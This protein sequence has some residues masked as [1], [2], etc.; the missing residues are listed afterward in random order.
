MTDQTPTAYTIVP[1]V[2]R[3]LASLINVAPDTNYAT[4]PVTLR[5]NATPVNGPNVQLIGPGQI[6]ALDSRSVVRT[7]PSN[8]ASAFEPNYFPMVEL[9]VPDL[10]W[11]F[12]PSPV[13][14]G[15]L[16]HWICLAVVGD[17]DGI[18]VESA[19]SGI[20]LLR[21]SAPADPASEL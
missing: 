10:P 14:N 12:T 3:G 9:A 11:T 8:G 17:T 18:A 13:V 5:V 2:R 1:W 4:L 15:R 16:Q 7:D 19:R 20:S 21:F 6:T